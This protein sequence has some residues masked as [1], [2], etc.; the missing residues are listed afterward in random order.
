M[1]KLFL[2]LAAVLSVALCASAQT[3]T[4]TGTV[5]D[6]SN[7]EPLMGASVTAGN[8]KTGV[9][10][11]IDG[12][13][14]ISVPAGVN[15]LHVSYI[16]Y[17]TQKVN[18]TG[19]KL[20]VKL[21]S[22]AEMLG[23]VIAVAYGTTTKGAYTGS[24]GVV[25]SKQLENVQVA[26]VTNALSGKVAGVQTLS[27]NGAP[28]QGAS[29]RIRGVGTINASASPLYVVDGM[30]IDGDIS[31]IAT[32]DIETMTVLKDAASTALYGARGANG[33]VMIT[34]KK[35]KEGQATVT[36]DLKWG[37]NGR[38]LSNYDVISDERQ[39]MET[40]Y[41][42][43]AGYNQ[44][45]LGYSDPQV[46]NNKSNEML[47]SGLGYQTWTIPEGELTVG[48]NG[49]FNPNAT[50]GYKKGNYWLTGDDWT[51]ESLIHGL[52]QEYNV[53]VSGGTNRLQYYVSA[54]YLGDEG[55]IKNSHF[56]R[57][58]TRASVDY[59]AKDWLKIGSNIQYAYQNSA[60]PG[61]NNLD[62]S[63]SSG[64]A[65]FM[66][67]TMAP[68]YPFYIRL[69]DTH[70]IAWNEQYN[71]PIYDYGDGIDYGWGSL[72]WVRNN[73]NQANA[74][75]ANTYD[76]ND[77]LSDVLDAKWYATLT[78]FKGFSLTGTAGYYVDN[79]R[80]HQI[81]NGVYG[82][83]RDAGGYAIQQADRSRSINLQ[84]IGQYD[85]TL[86]D[87]HNFTVMAGFENSAYRTENVWGNGGNLYNPLSPFLGNIIDSKNNGGD[88]AS[89]VHRG[90][91]GRLS[92]NFDNKYFATASVRRDGSSYFHPDHR[93][94]TFWSA[95]AGWNITKEGFME[96]YSDFWDI[97]KFKFSY[98]E[99]GNDGGIATLGTAWADIYRLTGGDGVWSDGTL[100]KKN[101]KDITWE[102]S[103]AINTGFDFSIKQG[104]FSGS[105]EYYQR[106]VSDML[107]HRP[108]PTSLGYASVP[109]NVGKMKN[110]GF[111]FDLNYRP[112]NTKNI[113][114]DL[115][116]NLTLG[117]NRVLEL[118]DYLLTENENW[119][120]D[121]KMGWLNGS[122]LFLEG[123]SMYN[124][125]MIEW[126]GVNPTTGEGEFWAL[127]DNVVRNSD[128]QPINA[129]GEVVPEGS[130][131][132]QPITTYT[133][134]VF[135]E[136]TGKYE[137]KTIPGKEAYRTPNQNTAYQ[138]NRKQTGNIMPKGYGGFG[139]DLQAYGFDLSASFAYQFGG[140]IYDNTYVQ[141]MSAYRTNTGIGQNMHK[142]LL[143]AWTPENTNT[144]IPRLEYNS[145]YNPNYTSTRFLISSNYLSL[146]NL[147]VGYTLPAKWLQ[148]LQLKSIRVYFAAENLA[149]WSKRKGL[150][151]RQGY[152]SSNNNTYSP[153]RSLSGG[154]RVQF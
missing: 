25:D 12:N 125:Y 101:N 117:W 61:D 102:K 112:I 87:L 152:V 62:E 93:W 103:A 54:A 74:I 105:V 11:D 141:F 8:A 27:S 30:P 19:N 82:Q 52:R 113:T 17:K 39:Y 15:T 104:M 59:Q 47:W 23:E 137:E 75:G 3:R 81:Q 71:K 29:I 154:I 28:G 41:Q 114:L 150:D 79:T 127:R 129:A 107:F 40:L 123:E 10:T 20:V 84:L 149:M 118:P 70:Q 139:F 46:I 133:Y 119:R 132:V 34:T 128:G 1:K 67:N 4:V 110:A 124:M 7:D 126:A 48:M 18:I 151:P 33:V 16:G 116:A 88:E 97:L 98:G 26:N 83:F 135:N 9:A 78:P 153:M 51:K 73:M 42:A 53:S 100:Y 72:G 38:A 94:G 45:R 35:G 115:N 131:D 92:Y 66:A 136:E 36:F 55:I 96:D 80:L 143:N 89:V 122:R 21:H 32:S 145:A 99:N 60:Y 120:P 85:F 5:L 142:D 121:S 2:L 22:D 6:E 50:K 140:K 95:S 147:T 64:N 43:Y 106:I 68:V 24:A 91:F 134:K 138:T 49:K 76:K 57:F 146:N 44:Y 130:D 109:D 56:K 13:F 90:F 86:K 65:F 69:A 111:E 108:V 58:T 77:Y 14:A 63:T 37:S 144:D 148:A 31:T